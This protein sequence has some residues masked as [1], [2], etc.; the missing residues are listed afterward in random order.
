MSLELKYTSSVTIDGLKLLFQ[1]TTGIYQ[2]TTN[3]T[4]WGTP[5]IDTSDSIL[6]KLE[7]IFP[8]ETE[9]DIHTLDISTDFPSSDTSKAIE[10]TMEDFDG[11]E[12]DIFPDGVYNIIYTISTET[13]DYVTSKYVFAFSQVKCCVESMF[14]NL[15]PI[16]CNGSCLEA[17][18]DALTTWAYYKALLANATCGDI[19]KVNELLELVNK[20]CS[21]R[22]NCANCN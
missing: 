13:E 15:D 6:A 12:G 17:A 14:K 3:P 18:E 21:G 2:A 10:F 5:N 7:I 11:E 22:G 19:A 8:N 9:D 20:M 4:G 1:E 16:G